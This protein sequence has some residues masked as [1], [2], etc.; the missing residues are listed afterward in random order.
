[1][2]GVEQTLESIIGKIVK[3]DPEA[4]GVL[5]GDVLEWPAWYYGLV[6]GEVKFPTRHQNVLLEYTGPVLTE[7]VSVFD[8]AVRS[9]VKGSAPDGRGRLAKPDVAGIED[10][11]RSV[12]ERVLYWGEWYPQ[13]AK[14][15]EYDSYWQDLRDHF[16]IYSSSYGDLDRDSEGVFVPII[17]SARV[18][19]LDFYNDCHSEGTGKFCSDGR[20]LVSV[21]VD[22]RDLR[23]HHGERISILQ[24]VVDSVNSV[25]GVPEGYPEARVEIWS[26]LQGAH[27]TY[28]P[29]GN[30]IRLSEDS[31]FNSSTLV[32]ELGHHFTLAESGEGKM[33]FLKRVKKNPELNLWLEAVRAT[34]QHKIL[35]EREGAGSEHASYLR[36]SRE[37]FA[38][39]YAQWIADRSGSG[40]LKSQH[41][42]IRSVDNLY[43]W[44]DS[45]FKPIGLALDNY[46]SSIG[47]LR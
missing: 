37:L 35:L 26:D 13:Y 28:D 4:V 9:Y 20:S 43:Q 17:S 3:G 8:R 45:E 7:L 16:E 12:L 44:S 6:E 33:D 32:H 42:F 11:V 1:M 5:L 25:V 14:Q 22:L 21:G 38:R 39:S 40:V 15:L 2:A 46:F 23:K 34:P 36:D 47:W 29:G 31:E 18:G 19:V 27:G 30:V 41:D 10:I 24:E